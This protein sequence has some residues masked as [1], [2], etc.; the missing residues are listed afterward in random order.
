MAEL[1]SRVVYYPD[2]NEYPGDN[3]QNLLGL[4]G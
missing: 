1:N 4:S 2:L 3:M